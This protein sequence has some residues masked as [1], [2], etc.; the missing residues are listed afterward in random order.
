MSS[1]EFS[2]WQA[3]WNLEP[4]GERVV[5]YQ[6]ATLCALMANAFRD[7]EMQPEPFETE[8]FMPAG[9]ARSIDA[10]DEMDE[11]EPELLYA[12]LRAALMGNSRGNPQ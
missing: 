2:E 3:Y 6:L 9:P 12:R 5:Q 7:P 10:T 1:R 4:F 11:P 8:D